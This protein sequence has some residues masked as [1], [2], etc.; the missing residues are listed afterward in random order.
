MSVGRKLL[1][2]VTEK[3]K[4]YQNSERKEPQEA[5]EAQENVLFL[6]PPLV[7]ALLFVQ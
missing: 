1:R 3:S 7:I 6:V 5:K 2:Q 4:I